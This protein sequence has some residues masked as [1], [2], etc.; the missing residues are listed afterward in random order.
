MNGW[1]CANCQL[2]L[3]G[4]NFRHHTVYV[5]DDW[6][7]NLFRQP[8]GNQAKDE[9]LIAGTVFVKK[10]RRGLGTYY[11]QRKINYRLLR[12]IG[13]PSAIAANASSNKATNDI[14]KNGLAGMDLRMG[15]A[16]VGASSSKEKN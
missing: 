7:C 1:I 9:E 2:A 11:E 10:T 8:Q 13:V 6:R 16:L 14:I 3:V 15:G 5:C 4:I 12:S